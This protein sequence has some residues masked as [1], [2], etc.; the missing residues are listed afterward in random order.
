MEEINY[1]FLPELDFHPDYVEEEGEEEVSLPSANEKTFLSRGRDPFIS[2]GSRSSDHSEPSSQADNT[3]PEMDHHEYQWPAADE[4]TLPAYELAMQRF[5]S[6]CRETN[7]SPDWFFEKGSEHLPRRRTAY[8]FTAFATDIELLADHL[9]EMFEQNGE[10]YIQ[11]LTWQHE[12]APTTGTNHLQG[13]IKCKGRHQMNFVKNTILKLQD[14]PVPVSMYLFFHRDDQKAIKYAMKPF[15]RVNGG[16]HGDLGKYQDRDSSYDET[17]KRKLSEK[18]LMKIEIVTKLQQEIDPD[19]GHALVLIEYPDFLSSFTQLWEASRAMRRREKKHERKAKAEKM[20][21]RVWQTCLRDELES[22]TDDRKIIVYVDKKGGAGKST[23][24]K[25]M[26]DMH[27]DDHIYGENVKA[28]DFK[29]VISKHPHPRTILINLTRTVNDH[30][31]YQVYEAVKDGQ[32]T[33]GKY[34]SRNVKIDSPNMV[35]FTNEHLDYTAMSEDRWDIRE[36]I[37]NPVTKDWDVRRYKGPKDPRLDIEPP[38][39]RQRLD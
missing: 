24:I 3:Y 22:T 2:R 21:L 16:Y 27:P 28:N 5:D 35:F 11:Y 26:T 39:K 9:E 32:F 1:N 10:Q 13:F 30:V 19:E 23:L 15:S 14:A 33:S 12:R 36:L 8:S 25:Y 4:E 7:A 29:H 20:Q 6:F 37:P 17:M 34:D 38:M 31:G 18:G